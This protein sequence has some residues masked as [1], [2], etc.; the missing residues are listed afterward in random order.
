MWRCEVTIDGDRVSPS[1][2]IVL[3]PL[4]GTCPLLVGRFNPQSGKPWGRG[5][6]WKALPD[7]RVL[8]AVDEAVLDG[9][10]QSLRNTLIYADDGFI[11]FSEG[12][13][14]GRAYP[15]ARGFTREQI[16]ELN[17]GVNLDVGWMSEERREDRLRSAFYQDGPRQKGDTP[18]TASQWMDERR[19]VQQRMGKPSAPLWTEIILP[20]IQRIEFLAVEMGK[21]DAQLTV[22][23]D[24]ISV[25]PI[26]PLQKAQNQDQVMVSRS[27]LD[28]AFAVAGEMTPQIIDL[29]STL[30]KHIDASGDKLTVLAPQDANA[31]ATPPQ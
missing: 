16:Y 12:I 5:P 1:D 30:K 9:L 11:D 24:V 31:A 19:R 7:M 14:A 23:G 3:G 10:D 26:S 29:H 8:N 25:Q 15:A 18:P 22:A 17:R 21:L 28:T 6:A 2:P 20:F 27:N 13:E 4:A